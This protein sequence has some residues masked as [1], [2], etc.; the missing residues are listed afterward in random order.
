M[1]A[2]DGSTHVPVPP[3]SDSIERLF[4]YHDPSVEQARAYKDIRIAA[5]AL[6]YIIDKECPAGPD[7]TVAV[8][9]IRE[10]VM[11]ANASIATGNAIYR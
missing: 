9:K 11:T 4:T 10:A 5:K 2:P 7:R 8:R 3:P 6:V 1:Q